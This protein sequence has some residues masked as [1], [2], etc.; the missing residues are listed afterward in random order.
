MASMRVS[1]LCATMSRKLVQSAMS[2]RK[3]TQLR[4]SPMVLW[5]CSTS[6]PAVN[7]RIVRSVAPVILCART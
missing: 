5:N 6:R 7:A 4:N 1:L 3:G 2:V